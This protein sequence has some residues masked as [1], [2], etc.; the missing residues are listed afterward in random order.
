MSLKNYLPLLWL[1]LLPGILCAQIDTTEMPAELKAGIER[2]LRMVEEAQR[3]YDDS[4]APHPAG[5][6]LPIPRHPA[7]ELLAPAGKMSPPGLK[8]G[9]GRAGSIELEL[10]AAV[11]YR[12]GAEE[13]RLD[14][15]LRTAWARGES[16]SVSYER[17]GRGPVKLSCRVD[18]VGPGLNY[19]FDLEN[20]GKDTL[21]NLQLLVP[22]ALEG[23]PAFSAFHTPPNSAGSRVLDNGILGHLFLF[24]SGS[25]ISADRALQAAGLEKSL[26]L[27]FGPDGGKPGPL[28]EIMGANPDLMPGVRLQGNTVYLL[29]NDRRWRLEVS[30]SPAMSICCRFKPLRL[31]VN[32]GAAVLAPKEKTSVGGIIF[33]NPAD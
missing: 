13:F 19:R 17:R 21:F 1:A 26:Y 28:A 25:W 30:A 29:S 32:P 4:L 16:G 12:V 11:F 10:P 14:S 5:A 27:P 15:L 24:L 8:A 2:M 7:W 3:F 22:A 9:I 33:L 18:C 31:Y 20:T 6:A 23:L